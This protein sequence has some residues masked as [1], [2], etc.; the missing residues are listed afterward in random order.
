MPSVR[1]VSIKF[2]VLLV[3]VILPFSVFAESA[4]QR[5]GKIKKQEPSFATILE[6]YFKQEHVTNEGL[7]K[8]QKRVRRAPLLPQLYVGID[9]QLKEDQ[10]LGIG[11]NITISGGEVTIGPDESSY[12]YSEN[13]GTTFRVRAV[14]KLDEL[15]FNRNEL[16]VSK[17]K[18]ELAKSRSTLTQDVHKVYDQRYLSLLSYFQNKGSAKGAQYYVK[19]LSLTE[20][21]N[22]LT[23]RE[24][25]GRWWGFGT[26]VRAHERTSSR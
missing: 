24:F 15:V 14:W 23:G 3:V 7:A 12:D 5:V 16:L 9:V 25:E 13:L 22:A 20:Q 17:E 21:L 4:Q 11:D 26:S 8:L 19:Y 2:I 1:I 18:Q 10:S 6:T